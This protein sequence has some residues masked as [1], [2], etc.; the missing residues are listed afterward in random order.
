MISEEVLERLS[1]RLVDRIENLNTFMINKLGEQIV[2]IGTFTPSQVRKVLQSVKYGNNL[3]EIMKKISEITD[4]NIKDIYEIFEEVAKQNQEYAKQ[5]YEYKKVNFIPYEQ[6]R[7][8]QE[9]VKNIAKATANEYINISNTLAYMKTNSNGLKEY[10]K[11]SDIYQKITDEAILNISQGRDSYEMTMKHAMREMTANGLKTIDF[12]TG[13]S[14]RADS[15][16]RMNIM[17]GIRRLSRNLQEEFGKEF[18]ADG[19][20]VSHHKYAAPDHIDTIDGRQFSTKGEVIINGIKYQD[21]NI[22][23]YNLDRHVGELNCYHFPM[24]IVLGVSKPLY[25]KEQLEADKKDNMKGF[26]FE[27]NH[28]TMYEGTQLQR[29]IETK[30]RQYKDRQ[31]G[32]KSINDMDEVYRCQEKISQLTNKYKELSDI[33]GLPTKIDRLKVEGYKKISVKKSIEYFDLSNS[34]NLSIKSNIQEAINI[35]PDHIRQ[36]CKNTKFK[37]GDVNKYVPKDDIIYINTKADKYSVIHEIGHVLDKKLNIFNDKQFID[38]I[39]SKFKNYKRYDFELIRYQNGAIL[40]HLKNSKD[41]VSKYQTTLYPFTGNKKAFNLMNKVNYL[42]AKEYFSEG[43]KYYFLNPELLKEK[44][45][46]LFK[47]I[48]KILEETK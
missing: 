8:L 5:F 45:L 48:K 34:N 16:I 29:Q 4:I 30:I 20:E 41:F 14:R 35:L 1:E 7:T 28:Y 31:I 39:K 6:N 11:I 37:I 3:N 15:S 13:Y 17:D 23:N 12:A 9:H 24:Q 22:V 18:G 38:T 32:A 2:D 46:K 19:I 26:D 27:G 10:T 33:S 44:D 47:Y 21:Y 42:N 36:V 40:Y 25:S 43:L